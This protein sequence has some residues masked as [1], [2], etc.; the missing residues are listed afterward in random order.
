MKRIG[1]FIL[2]VSLLPVLATPP[3]IALFVLF[4]VPDQ[5][6]ETSVRDPDHRPRGR[7]RAHPV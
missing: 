5:R 1:V 7:A 6:D 4:V 3:V 2:R